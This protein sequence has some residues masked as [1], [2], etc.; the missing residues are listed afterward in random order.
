MR[1]SISTWTLPQTSAIYATNA[2][3][4]SAMNVQVG[5]LWYEMPD[6]NKVALPRPVLVR[7]LGQDSGL[8]VVNGDNK[9]IVGRQGTL[10][11]A[12]VIN[13]IDGAYDSTKTRFCIRA[14]QS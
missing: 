10:L 1:H 7:T 13:K 2:P 5:Y 3:T 12:I 6:P 4:F 9:V 8:A 14:A 11:Q